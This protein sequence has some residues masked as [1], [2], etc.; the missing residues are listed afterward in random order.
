[1]PVVD[2]DGNIV[3]SE[4][5]TIQY[6]AWRFE[7]EGYLLL[8]DSVG[9]WSLVGTGEAEES[10]HLTRGTLWAVL[11]RLSTRLFV[12]DSSET[13]ALSGSSAGTSRDPMPKGDTK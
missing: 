4:E 2:Q 12:A 9:R 6:L 5:R 10:A 7:D 1:M 13:T 8:L 11:S 3:S